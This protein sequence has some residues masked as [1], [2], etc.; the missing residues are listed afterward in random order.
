MKTNK[1]P[2]KIL[3]KRA[4]EHANEIEKLKAI[5]HEQYSS[6]LFTNEEINNHMECIEMI[7]EVI[8]KLL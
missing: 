4:I 1:Y 8:N 5:D 6:M 3:K 2:I 7:N